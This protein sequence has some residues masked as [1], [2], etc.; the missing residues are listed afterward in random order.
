MPIVLHALAPDVALQAAVE[1]RLGG[2]LPAEIRHPDAATGRRR[3]ARSLGAGAIGLVIRR[4]GPLAAP[5]RQLRFPLPLTAVAVG[6][7]TTPCPPL[8]T[9][10]YRAAAC[11]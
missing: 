2:D 11:P 9:C 10:W 7:R 8:F 4:P 5:D 6:P 1:A 3:G